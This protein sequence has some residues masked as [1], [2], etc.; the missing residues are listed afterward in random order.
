MLCCRRSDPRRSHYRLVYFD[1][2]GLAEPIR[3]IFHYESVDFQ[4]TRLTMEEWQDYKQ[5]KFVEIKSHAISRFLATQFGLNG[6]TDWDRALIDQYAG[7][8]KDFIRE[9]NPY[10]FVLMGRAEGDKKKMRKQVFQPAVNRVFP[11][12]VRA[13]DESKSGF[14]LTNGLSWVDFHYVEYIV[15]VKNL[16]PNAFKKYRELLAYVER[17]H[18]L[19]A[20]HDYIKIRPSSDV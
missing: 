18:S 9:L 14:L 19:P 6:K 20:L 17:V 15:S 10:L 2:R 8:L 5:G 4:D 7:L 16:E 12:F 3:M 13:L 11:L 1:V